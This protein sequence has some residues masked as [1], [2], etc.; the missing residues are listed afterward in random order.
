MCVAL[1][2]KVIKMDGTKAT[3]DF[4]GNIVTAE[5]GLVKVNVGDRVLVHAGCIIQTMDDKTA[6]ELED[7]FKEIEDITV[8]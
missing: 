6:D 1:P 2:G 3:V 5:A 8:G 7:M 4:S